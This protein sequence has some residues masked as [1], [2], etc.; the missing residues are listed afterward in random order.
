MSKASKTTTKPVD[1][2]LLVAAKH[3]VACMERDTACHILSG[4]LKTPLDKRLAA[5]KRKHKYTGHMPQPLYE[6]Q[7]AIRDR[8]E[9]TVAGKKYRTAWNEFQAAATASNKACTRVLNYSPKSLAGAAY[10]ALAAIGRYN[11]TGCGYSYSSDETAML[12]AFK[13]FQA[14]GL[15]LPPAVRRA[16]KQNEILAAM[17]RRFAV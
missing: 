7:E 2:A 6:Q 4:Q 8:W 5:F 1:V 17:L 14:A 12:I 9:E 13:L 15:R 11:T 3:M 16:A 10:V